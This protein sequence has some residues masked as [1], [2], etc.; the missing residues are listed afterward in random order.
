MEKEKYE[1]EETLADLVDSI[2]D[3]MQ[4]DL[5]DAKRIEGGGPNYRYTEKDVW[6]DIHANRAEG[7]VGEPAE[8][9]RNI[10]PLFRKSTK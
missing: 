1:E 5:E 2:R 9:D 8:S 4:R 6:D 10:A 3:D 7:F